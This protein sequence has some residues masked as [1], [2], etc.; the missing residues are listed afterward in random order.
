MRYSI[1]L[2][3]T[4]FCQR[5]LVPNSVSRFQVCETNGSYFFVQDTSKLTLAKNWN[6]ETLDGMLNRTL[7]CKSTHQVFMSGGGILTG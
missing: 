6:R 1:P 5:I 3:E 7:C 4:C 2:E